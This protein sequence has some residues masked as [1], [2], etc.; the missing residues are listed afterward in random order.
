MRLIIEKDRFILSISIGGVGTSMLPLISSDNR[1]SYFPAFAVY[2]D[3]KKQGVTKAIKAKQ[4]NIIK[5]YH[6]KM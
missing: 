2:C 3:K 6:E 4:N 5:R 1:L